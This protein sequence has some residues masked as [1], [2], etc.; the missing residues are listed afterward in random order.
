MQY[1]AIAFYLAVCLLIQWV[2]RKIAQLLIYHFER[3]RWDRVDH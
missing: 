2:L 1:L 3:W